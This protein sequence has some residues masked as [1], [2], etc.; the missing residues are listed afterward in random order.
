LDITSAAF[1]T[2]SQRSQQD[3]I[4]EPNAEW[5][6]QQM[7]EAFPFDAAPKYLLRDRD[8]IYGQEFR[9][10]VEIMNINEVLSAPRSPWQSYLS[11][12][13]SRNW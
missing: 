6:A 4:F 11:F 2:F 8:R 10:Q 9:K 12:P 1:T 5:T 3:R 7:L 13:S